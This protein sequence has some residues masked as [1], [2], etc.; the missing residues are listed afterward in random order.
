MMEPDFVKLKEIKPA[1]AGYI[2]ESLALLNKSVVPDDNVVHDVRVLMKKARSGVRLIAEQM[3]TIFIDREMQALREVGRIL[4]SW[5]DIS[6]LR[7]A[8]KN[9]KKKHP[10]IFSKLEDNEKINV[11]MKKPELIEELPVEGKK[12]LAQIVGI[13][14]KS[15]YRI[16]FESMGKLDP[17]KLIKSL[18]ASYIS[19][20][21]NYMICRN[22]P[23]PANLHELRKRAKDFHFQ[24]WFFRPLNPSVVKALE[25]KLDLLTQ[26]LGKYNDLSQLLK[27]IGYKYEY[28][29]NHPALDELAVIIRE[30]QDRNLAKV[31]PSAHKIFCP[32]QK[33]VNVLGF[34]LLVI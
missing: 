29:A 3:D 20:V 22:D 9:L 28:S 33:L 6:V 21:N 24:L 30:E 31:W 11:L 25:K 26:N 16:R 4:S 15:V 5:R 13:L 2:S 18:E 10:D 17:H 34:K 14:N 1:L 19:V 12:N 23:K 32:G 27:E 7:K 8:L